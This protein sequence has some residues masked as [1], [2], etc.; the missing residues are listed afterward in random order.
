MSSN[1]KFSKSSGVGSLTARGSIYQNN[2]PTKLLK[3]PLMR[4][5]KLD[6]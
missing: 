3:S 1:I 2:S 5:I 4:K 6:S